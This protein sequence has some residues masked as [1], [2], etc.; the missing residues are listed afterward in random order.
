MLSVAHLKHK[1]EK[2]DLTVRVVLDNTSA[3]HITAM[4]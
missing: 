4:F 1:T 3:V 2:A